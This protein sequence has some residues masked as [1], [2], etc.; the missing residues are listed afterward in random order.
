MYYY[1]MLREHIFAPILGLQLNNV[2]FAKNNLV[3]IK[4]T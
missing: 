1:V 4:D 2:V 3:Y